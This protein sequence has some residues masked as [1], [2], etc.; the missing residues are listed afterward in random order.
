[1]FAYLS[2]KV[3][4][5]IKHI[6]IILSLD[7]NAKWHYAKYCRMELRERLSRSWWRLRSPQNS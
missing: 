6:K 4:S 7:F 3:C 1:M 2:K 5:K